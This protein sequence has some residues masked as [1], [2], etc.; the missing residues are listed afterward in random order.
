MNSRPLFQLSPRL[1]L[2]ASLV[3]EGASMADIGT[4]HAY[5]PVWLAKSGK[6]RR[7]IACDL[8]EGP[9]QRAK[10]HVRRYAVESRVETRLSDG[11]QAVR[12]DEVDTVVIAGMGGEVIAGILEQAPWLKEGKTL[13]LQAMTSAE[14]LRLW[15]QKERYRVIQEKAVRSE[16][17]IYTVMLVQYENEPFQYGPFYPYIGLLERDRSPEAQEYIARKIRHLQNRVKGLQARQKCQEAATLL[18][19]IE[20]L[21]RLTG[22]I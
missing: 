17:R 10:E 13:I 19:V 16:G 21:R 20:G 18:H 15:L 7:A 12:P 5:L 2:C 6:V 1:F 9:I 8:R 11:L 22:E 4:D 3:P 14:E